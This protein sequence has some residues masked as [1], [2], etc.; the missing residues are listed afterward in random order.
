MDGFSTALV[1]SA[2]IAFAG[3]VVAAA[4]VRVHELG[5]APEGVPE[6]A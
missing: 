2:A 5:P 6:V 1:V 4:L 3:A